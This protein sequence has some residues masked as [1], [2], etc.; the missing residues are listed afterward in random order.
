MVSLL[1]DA[2]AGTAAP[3]ASSGGARRGGRGGEGPAGGYSVR[4]FWRASPRTFF[5]AL[6]VS[7]TIRASRTTR[8]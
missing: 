5:V 7:S 4:T 2:R 6:R 1:G 8:A 3:Y